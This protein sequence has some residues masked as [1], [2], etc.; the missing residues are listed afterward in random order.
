MARREVADQERYRILEG[1]LLDRQNEIKNKLRSLR[2]TLP[3]ELSQVKDEEEQSMEDFVLGMDFAV[4]QMESETLKRIDEA[5]ARLQQGAY[6]ICSDC[7]EPISEARLRA[8][9]FAVLCR[10]C[11]EIAEGEGGRRTTISLHPR[12]SFEE[13]LSIS[14][15]NDRTPP[16]KEGVESRLFSYATGAARTEAAAASAPARRA[17]QRAPE[18]RSVRTPMPARR[19]RRG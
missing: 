2:H 13:S 4:M 8:L 18:Q 5:M 6:G 7:D 12:H 19:S 9:P 17:A 10:D 14:A 1:M 15:R 11:Q 3:A 16:G